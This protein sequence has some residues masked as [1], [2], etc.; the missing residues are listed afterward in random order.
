LMNTNSQG[1]GG[2][3]AVRLIWAGTTGTTRAY[4]STNTGNL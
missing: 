3:G 4:P 2:S 1:N